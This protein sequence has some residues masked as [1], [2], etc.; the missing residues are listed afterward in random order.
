MSIVCVLKNTRFGMIKRKLSGVFLKEN[1]SF[2]NF[3][4]SKRT[5]YLR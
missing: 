5:R 3:F 1:E 2:F 4:L